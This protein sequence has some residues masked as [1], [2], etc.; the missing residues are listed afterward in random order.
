ML[1][2]SRKEL[3]QAFNALNRDDASESETGSAS[4]GMAE[5]EDEAQALRSQIKTLAEQGRHAEMDVAISRMKQL[6]KMKRELLQPPSLLSVGARALAKH[7]HRGMEG[8][9]AGAASGSDAAKNQA[10]ETA[11]RTVLQEAVWGNLHQLP[12]GLPTFEVRVKQGYGARWTV[13][14]DGSTK[15]RGLLEPMM[16]DGHEKRWRH[17]LVTK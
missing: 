17:D 9:W 7:A 14:E 16:E 15:F 8:F 3:I 6:T 13:S 4:P 11:L 1:P 2:P 12:G 5:V 10:A